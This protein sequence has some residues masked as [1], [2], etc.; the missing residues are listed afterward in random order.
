M[1]DLGVWGVGGGVWELEAGSEIGSR[2][3]SS[4]PHPP[5]PTPGTSKRRSLLRLSMH[6]R[7]IRD[8]RIPLQQRRNVAGA[9]AGA[10]VQLPH[11]V[12]HEVV[13]RIDDVRAVILMAGE[14]HLHDAVSRN[15]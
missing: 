9:G 11:L 14:M 12:D 15:R 6:R 3:G 10:A 4:T 2:C 1:R 7:K 13:V 5:L 8:I